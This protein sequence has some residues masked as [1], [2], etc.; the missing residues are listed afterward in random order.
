MYVCLGATHGRMEQCVTDVGPI[1]TVYSGIMQ[2]DKCRLIS[3]TTIM[4]ADKNFKIFCNS[5]CPF[6]SFVIDDIRS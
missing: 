4:F 6:T 1:K 2:G 3:F 5:A